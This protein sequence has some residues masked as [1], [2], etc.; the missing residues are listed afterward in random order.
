M[1]ADLRFRGSAAALLWTDRFYKEESGDV[2]S[3]LEMFSLG[4]RSW[5]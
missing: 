3:L 1:H 4:Q 5:A 2:W